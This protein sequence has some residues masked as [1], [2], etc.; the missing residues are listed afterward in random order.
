MKGGA[1]DRFP[2]LVAHGIHS[3]TV[4]DL[5]LFFKADVTS[6]NIIPTI[7]ADLRDR[8]AILFNAPDIPVNSMFATPGMRILDRVLSHMDNP[9]YDIREYN[10]LERI[11]HAMHMQEVWHGASIEYAK[12]AKTP[13]SKELCLCVTDVDN[14]GVMEV[15]RLMALEVREPNLMYGKSI[16]LNNG[17]MLWDNIHYSFSSRINRK[18][19]EPLRKSSEAMTHVT[20]EKSWKAMK[21]EIMSGMLPTDDYELALY[22]YCALNA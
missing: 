1:S 9:D 2:G 6:K 12:L 5:Q 14:N 11:I 18:A 15:L 4:G 8:Q 21:T 13:P 10:A 3:L 17:T 22:I 16:K 20:N 7:N 19:D